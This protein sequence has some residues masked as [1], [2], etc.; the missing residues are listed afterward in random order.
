MP[1]PKVHFLNVKQGDCFLLERDS[2]RL[3]MI[4]ICCG[5]LSSADLVEGMIEQLR[6]QKPPGNYA[7]CKAATNPIDYLTSHGL[8]SIWRF[9][10]TH[11][12]MDHMD[13]LSK[14]F[15][16]KTV[17]HFWD[18]GIRRQKPEFDLQSPYEEAD[19]DFYQKLITTGSP[20]T[21]TISP[22]AGD[23]G[24]FW[25]ADDDD[26]NG[27]GD[28]ISIVSP[29]DDLVDA[30]NK[31]GD[32]NDA[33]YVIV[34]RS[35]AGRIIFAGDSND[36][37]WEYILREHVDLIKNAAVLFAPHHGRKSDRDYSFLDVVKPRVSFFGCA[38]SG[39]LAY[40]AWRNRN[41]L[42]FTNNQCGNAH[43]CPQGNKVAVY[44]ECEAYA[45]AYT[46]GYT[47]QRDEYW[48]LCIV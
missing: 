37:T 33:S 2:G 8:S 44:I 6:T 19:W 30:A 46:T 14:L 20:G 45:R 38:P 43:I 21:K 4:D 16:E 18:C 42:Y 15:K 12:D 34:Y 23:N 25:N 39:E 1:E 3:T 13:G 10:L 32:I 28:Y 17:E 31:S 35:S 47:H 24:K 26:G 9:I 48:F 27:D 22:R 5:N 7:M 36:K 41:L 40:S 29:S 11:P